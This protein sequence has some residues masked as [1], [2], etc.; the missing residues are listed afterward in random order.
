MR[1]ATGFRPA[2][3][4]PLIKQ[5][6]GFNGSSPSNAAVLLAL[7]IFR[8]ARQLGCT[9]SRKCVGLEECLR[10]PDPWPFGTSWLTLVRTLVRAVHNRGSPIYIYIY[11]VL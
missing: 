6:I 5:I 8:V 7:P 9:Y 2:S 11:Y 3:P 1:F 4:K 10:Y